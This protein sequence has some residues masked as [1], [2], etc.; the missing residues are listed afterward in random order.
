[1][2][3]FAIPAASTKP[4]PSAATRTGQGTWRRELA[5]SGLEKALDVLMK[6]QDHLN[7]AVDQSGDGLSQMIDGINRSLR[8]LQRNVSPV[9]YRLGNGQ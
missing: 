2:N 5:M 8:E 7:T 4:S 9:S 1:M 3:A 6:A